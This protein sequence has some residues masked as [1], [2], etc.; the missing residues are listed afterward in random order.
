MLGN[1]E[2]EVIGAVSPDWIELRMSRTRIQACLL[3]VTYFIG[4]AVKYRSDLD[5]G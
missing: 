2:T 1:K 3:I 4:Y 5:Q